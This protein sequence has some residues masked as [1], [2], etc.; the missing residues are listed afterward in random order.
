MLT[1]LV[2]RSVFGVLMS[3]L[4]SL[5]LQRRSMGDRSS[6]GFR[7]ERFLEGVLVNLLNDVSPLLLNLFALL[8][9]A[10]I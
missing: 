10:E 4:G 2:N 8:F 1:P 6:L 3:L 5:K 7:N 9:R